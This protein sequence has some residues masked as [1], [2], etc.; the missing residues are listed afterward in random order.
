[1]ESDKAFMERMSKRLINKDDMKGMKQGTTKK[2][3][4]TEKWE[5][6][7]KRKQKENPGPLKLYT[8]TNS[9]IKLS[10]H[11]TELILC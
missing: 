1:M 4:G 5:R 11:S 8:E 10:K 3:V 6:K 2:F 9:G 7:Q